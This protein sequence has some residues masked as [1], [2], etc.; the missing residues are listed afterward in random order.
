MER[1]LAFTS[2]SYFIFLA[3]T[4]I[5]FVLLP[6]KMR[7]PI[8]IGSSLVFYI[9]FNS[10]YYIVFILNT[11]FV[12]YFSGIAIAKST[13]EMKR[14][15]LLYNAVLIELIILFFTKYWNPIANSTAMIQP[16]NLLVPLGISFYSF[17][18][19]GYIVDVYRG[20]VPAE[21]KFT[22]FALFI[23]FFPH[24]L[25][26]PIETAQSFIPQIKLQTTN[27]KL[28]LS[29]IFMIIIGLFKK[30]VIAD[31][32]GVYVDLIFNNPDSYKGAAIGLAVFFAKYQIYADFSGYTDIALGSA[33]LFGYKLTEN[34][35]R[36]FFSKNISEFWNRWHISLSLW[37]KRYI[38]YPLLS[39]PVN[40]LG[41]KGLTI[42]TFIFLG[43]WHGGT[44]NYII[45]GLIQGVFVIADFSTKTMRLKFYTKVGWDNYPRTLNFFATLFTFLFLIIPPTLFFRS[46][47]FST[48]MKLLSGLGQSSDFSFL[49]KSITLK[50]NLIFAII[51][52]FLYEYYDWFNK[53]KFNLID[54]ITNKSSILI[55]ISALILLLSILIFGNIESGSKFIYTQF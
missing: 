36:P 2:F 3:V 33:K 7:T 27:Q 39:S 8:L 53:S 47:D 40:F 55:F 16:I 30:I 6:K 29:G 22:S 11:I 45:Y 1:I 19:I 15:L 34:F 46:I 28:I 12:S 35:D 4:L 41:V 32:L 23:S 17:Q 38:F 42:L 5:L 14:K 44:I 37:I 51:A 31:N 20:V 21:K 26:G 13:S 24:L 43:L 49:A 48:S 52:S 54:W 9:S 50:N 18:S 10:P 25:A